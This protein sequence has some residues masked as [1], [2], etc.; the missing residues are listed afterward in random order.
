MVMIL[1]L[2]LL[3]LMLGSPGLSITG[4]IWVLLDLYLSESQVEI[5]HIVQ[6]S[7]MPNS[8]HADEKITF[9]LQKGLVCL[10]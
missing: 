1:L 7:R 8:H 5:F 3:L 6:G 4:N 10:S 2:H 9:P